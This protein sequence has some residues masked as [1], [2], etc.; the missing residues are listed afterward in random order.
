MARAD[1]I[2]TPHV[3][4]RSAEAERSLRTRVAEQV[5]AVLTTGNPPAFGRLA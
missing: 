4:F 3:A 2:A 5:A 1:V